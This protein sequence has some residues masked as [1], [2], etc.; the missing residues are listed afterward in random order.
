MTGTK[1]EGSIQ[2]ALSNFIPNKILETMLYEN[3]KKLGI[4]K[5]NENDRQFAKKIRDVLPEDNKRND[6][7]VLTVGELKGKDISDVI[8]P[9][10]KQE[11]TVPVSTDV[12]DVS[13]IVPTGIFNVACAALGTPIHSWA[14]VSQGN[15]SIAHTGMLH[16]GK[17]IASTAVEL[18][19]NP[20]LIQNAK[21]ELKERLGGESYICPIPRDIKA[22]TPKKA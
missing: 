2:S 7:N 5:Y 12:G 18:L 14:F 17:L 20:E 10:I 16:A 3:L 19:K 15:T 8:N 11:K 22:P 4:P 1:V 6:I 21:A 9:F 13:W